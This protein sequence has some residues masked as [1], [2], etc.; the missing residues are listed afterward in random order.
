[1]SRAQDSEGKLFFLGLPLPLS[2]G[3]QWHVV[4]P[5]ATDLAVT[6][7]VMRGRMVSG[8]CQWC[9]VSHLMV[10]LSNLSPDGEVVSVVESFCPA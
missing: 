9:E 1:M 2:A 5:H 6:G 10:C 3:A 4:L 8:D 7:I